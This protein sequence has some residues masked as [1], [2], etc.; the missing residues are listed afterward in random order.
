MGPTRPSKV[1]ASLNVLFLVKE[2][3]SNL[4]Q[5]INSTEERG[6]VFSY[7]SSGKGPFSTK[8]ESRGDVCGTKGWG[9]CSESLPDHVCRLIRFGDT[10]LRGSR[11]THTR[12]PLR[13]GFVRPS[14]FPPRVSYV[15]SVSVRLD[16]L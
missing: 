11:V 12:S 1:I 6:L 4:R 8:E 10:S 5:R 15:E 2:R 7:G 14:T 3:N 16:A 13:T 9:L